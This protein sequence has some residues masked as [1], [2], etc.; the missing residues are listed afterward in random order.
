MRKSR[1]VEEVA[2][3][4]RKRSIED[5]EEPDEKDQEVTRNHRSVGDEPL[6]G[7]KVNSNL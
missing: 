6:E 7:K 1:A 4:K 5:D 3:V 2:H